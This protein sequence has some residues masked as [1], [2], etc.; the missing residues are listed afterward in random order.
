MSKALAVVD[1]P[2]SCDEC[3]AFGNHYSDMVCKVN[4]AG[5]NYPYPKDF[6][7]SWCPLIPV[8]DEWIKQNLAPSCLHTNSV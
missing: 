2:N 7:Q 6:R 5:I 1:M 8:S 3:P 4:G